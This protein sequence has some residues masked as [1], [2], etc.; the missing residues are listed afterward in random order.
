MSAR[1]GGFLDR[2]DGF[3]AGVLRHL[4][5]RGAD[6]WIRSSG[7]CSRSRGR[8]S[9]TPGIAPDRLAGTPHR[10][11]RRRLQQP[12][13]S[14]VVLS[15]ATSAIDAYLASGNA[16]SV[17]AGRLSYFL[18]LQGP[19]LSIDTACSSSLVAVHLAVPEPAQRRVDAGARRRRQPDVLARDDASRCRKAHMLAPDGR[20][21]TFDAARRRLRRAA[22][23]AACS[24]SSGSPTRARDGD[25][26][27]RA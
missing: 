26:D 19:A 15:A 21:K 23:A 20:C 8:R 5:A 11:L 27:P 2:V 1:S 9:S 14:S 4:A 12:I 18:G 25:R 16:H 13:T 6:A 3:D 7:C 22:R 24:C 10:R 17:A